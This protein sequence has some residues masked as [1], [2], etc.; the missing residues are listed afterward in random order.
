MN[1]AKKPGNKISR[2]VKDQALLIGLIVIFLIFSLIT[3]N[4]WSKANILLILVSSLR[5]NRENKTELSWK[6]G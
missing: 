1:D 3:D 6:I 4:F 2:I 5:D